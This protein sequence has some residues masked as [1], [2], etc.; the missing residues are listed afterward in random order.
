MGILSPV[1]YPL[2]FGMI[3]GRSGADAFYQLERSCRIVS[4]GGG[5]PSLA[6]LDFANAFGSVSR[7]WILM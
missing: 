6:L 3:P 4:N 1:L 7:A 5:S 2:Q